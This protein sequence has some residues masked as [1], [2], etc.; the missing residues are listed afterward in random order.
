M[1]LSA[2]SQPSSCPSVNLAIVVTCAVALGLYPLP[3][4]DYS[5]DHLPSPLG[6]AHHKACR[7]DKTVGD[8]I[9]CVSKVRVSQA[10]SL[11]RDP[12]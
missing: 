10:I 11:G 1:V 2:L 3:P 8:G 9:V 12:F 6:A 7:G 4:Q 5:R